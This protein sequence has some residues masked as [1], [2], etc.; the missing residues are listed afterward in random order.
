MLAVVG[1][2]TRDLVDASAVRPGGAPLYAARALKT[3]GEPGLIVT[4]CAAEDER[5][6]DDLRATGIPVVW[7]P[8]T[9]SPTFRLRYRGGTREASIEALGEPWLPEDAEGWLGEA[10]AGADWVHAAALW[11]GDFPAETLARLARG[12]RVSLDGQGLARPSAV[13]RVV[14]D[15]AFDPALLE[16]VSVLHLSEDEADALGLEVDGRSLASLGVQEVVVTLGERGSAIWD[17]GT[18]ERVGASPVEN[19]DPTGAG[20]GFMA[21]YLARRRLGDLPAAAARRATAVVR[22]LLEVG[23]PA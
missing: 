22:E 8:E 7:R 6:L 17:G 10:L 20:D 12:R 21:A 23:G 11:R 14:H 3:L 16:H 5:L 18:L 2:T 13:G 15:G 19:A 1:H 9:A 4:R